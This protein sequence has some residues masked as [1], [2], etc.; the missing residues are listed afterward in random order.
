M[1]LG[2]QFRNLKSSN[3]L[4]SS[5]MSIINGCVETYV[6]NEGIVVNV[7]GMDILLDL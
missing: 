6:Q 2:E 4:K 5:L 7:E 1:C 3:A